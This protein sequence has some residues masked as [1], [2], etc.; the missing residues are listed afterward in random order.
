MAN[1]DEID[2]NE[3][4]NR[5]QNVSRE[6]Y[7]HQHWFPMIKNLISIYCIEKNVLDL[8]CGT[9]VISKEIKKYTDNLT[10]VDNSKE[11]IE[12]FK[13]R[14]NNINVLLA[15]AHNL[16]FDYQTFDVVITIGLF[17]YVDKKKVI[18][19]IDY[20]LKQ[21]GYLIIQTPNKYNPDLIITKIITKILNRTYDRK[22]SSK[23]EM[24]NLLR[25]NNFEII[26][27]I[28]DDGLIWLPDFLDKYIGIKIYKTIEKF[29]KPLKQN[30]LSTNMLFIVKKA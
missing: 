2:L 11:M 17:E 20:V 28:M 1:Y 29:F 24:I 21:S 26:E 14:I 6:K 10:S 4:D 15:D 7:L 27:F 18:E 22:E 12:F 8:G 23:K 9:G 5:H 13:H 3:W 16:P 30:P 19:E 25:E